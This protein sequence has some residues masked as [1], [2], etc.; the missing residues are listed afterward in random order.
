M[1]PY[2]TAFP[3]TRCRESTI[4]SCGTEQRLRAGRDCVAQGHFSRANVLSSV[5][6]EPRYFFEEKCLYPLQLPVEPVLLQV[7][8]MHDAVVNFVCVFTCLQETLLEWCDELELNLILTTGGTGFAPRDVTPEVQTHEAT[9]TAKLKKI[10][11]IT[12]IKTSSLE[13]K[14]APPHLYLVLKGGLYPDTLSS[15]EKMCKCF[16]IAM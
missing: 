14:L 9:E 5:E 16:M 10:N 6:F 13:N 2:F 12:I 11:Y 7:K 4:L 1:I 8:R 3:A 15:Y